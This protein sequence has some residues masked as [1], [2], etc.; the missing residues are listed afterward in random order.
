MASE[1]VLVGD[2]GGTNA[3]FAIGERRA[4]GGI[5]I[6]HFKKLR[7][8][9]FPDF[10]PAV[11]AYLD[12]LPNK[13]RPR[14]ALFALAGPV[15]NNRVRL[16]NRQGWDADGNA[17]AEELGFEAV[18]IVNDYAAMARAIPEL[19]ETAFRTLQDAPGLPGEPILVAG[20]GTGI[21]VATLIPLQ[22]GGYHALTGEGGHSTYPAVTERE[23][24]L[25]A[26]LQRRHGY[27][28]RELVLAGMGLDPVMEALAAIDGQVHVRR[29]PQEVIDL[30]RAGDGFCREVIELR[31][32]GLMQALGDVALTNGTRGGVVVTGGV[33]ERIVDWLD[34]PE[35]LARFNRRGK[36]SDYMQAIPIRLLLSDDAPLIG[37]A[38]LAFE[39]N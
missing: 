3:R 38:A 5:D 10:E 7:G 13:E 14:R 16:T 15:I 1:T 2:V 27:V 23:M 17:I 4:T 31:A 32:H 22:G 18:H 35:A 8:D 39:R 37:A 34:T 26:E 21:G 9:D 25:S 36:Q 24:Q 6:H 33:A 11:G 19:P 20:P 30:A 29:E 12:S 28:S